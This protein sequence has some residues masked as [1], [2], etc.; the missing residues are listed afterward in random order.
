MMEH[1]VFSTHKSFL[2]IIFI[3][4]R[5]FIWRFHGAFRL[6]QIITSFVTRFDKIF[7]VVS[8]KAE[9]SS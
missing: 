8:L 6:S 3:T 9:T 4:I 1:T 2:E 7:V 5:L